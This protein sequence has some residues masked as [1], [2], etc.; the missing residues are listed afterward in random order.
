MEE[1]PTSNSNS[2]AQWLRWEPHV[3]AP[4]TVL[5]D[6]FKGAQAWEDYLT[7]LESA[8]PAL[9]AI[10][11]TDYYSTEIYERV[12]AAKRAGSFLAPS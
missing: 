12:L 10:G 11:I 4:G 8:K 1:G 6:Q 9:R 5:N 2:G 3:H 7:K